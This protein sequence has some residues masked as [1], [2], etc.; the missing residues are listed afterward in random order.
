MGHGIFFQKTPTMAD[1]RFLRAPF[2]LVHPVDTLFM[3]FVD[4]TVIKQTSIY[5][6]KKMEVIIFVIKVI[7]I[8]CMQSIQ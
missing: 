5:G 2:F 7:V 3:S 8:L 4:W 6:C 1:F